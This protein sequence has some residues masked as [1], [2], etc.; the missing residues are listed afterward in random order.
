MRSR[1]ISNVQT[2]EYLM[3]PKTWIA[4]GALIGALGVALGAFG[5]HGLGDRL[6]G[7]GLSPEEV[8]KRLATYETAARYQMY[9][10]LALVAVGLLA[11]QSPTRACQIAGVAFLVGVLV[12][13]GFLYA[14]VLTGVKV[15][16]AIVPIGGVAF[17]VGW[18]ALAWAA[19]GLK[20]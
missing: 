1:Q 19:L 13:S 7:W 8:A 3:Q 2:R 20:P 11:Q 5:A 9:H 15:L 14:L 18:L 12:F 10:A 16:G 17:I 6:A 4:C